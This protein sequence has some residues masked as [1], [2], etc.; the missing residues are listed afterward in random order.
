MRRRDLLVL[1]MV[2][3]APLA[4]RRG[5]SGR[6]ELLEL[7]PA[8]RA[9]VFEGF[10]TSINTWQQDVVDFTRS[11]D[12]PRLYLETVGASA[13]RVDLFGP[14]VPQRGKPAQISFRDFQFGGLAARGALALETAARLT[15]ASAERLRV[16]ATVWSPPGWMKHNGSRN[17]G[18]PSRRNFALSMDELACP[19]GL[20]ACSA[21]ASEERRRY[22]LTN[23]LRSDHLRHFAKSLVEWTR[24]FAEHGVSLAGLGPQNEPRFSHWFSSAVYHPEELAEVIDVIIEVFEAEGEKLPPLFAPET[25][26]HDEEANRLY[27]GAVMRRPRAARHLHALAAHG[28]VDGYAADEDPESTRRF[29]RIARAYDK[30]V[31]MT[32]GSTGGHDWPAPLHELGVSLMLSLTAGRA[33]LI[34]PWQIASR[35]PDKHGLVSLRGATKKTWVAAHFFRFIRPGMVRLSPAEGDVAE[36]SVAFLEPSTGRVVLVLINRAKAS[37]AW[38]VRLAGT[39]PTIVEAYMTSQDDTLRPMG[40]PSSAE[41]RLP[42]QSIVTAVIR[43]GAQA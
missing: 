24:L 16:I 29:L 27:V 2:L 17:N 5:P 28:Y 12:F 33:S 19:G 20:D 3:A 31:W 25:M 42:G 38:S 13:L 36:D 43:P 35:S 14:C 40:T 39:L 30:P 6:A 4:C 8:R 18:H 41:L 10:G 32:E 1:P 22:L 9:Q 15:R 7:D 21:K 23:R 26:S 34:T 11:A 37:R